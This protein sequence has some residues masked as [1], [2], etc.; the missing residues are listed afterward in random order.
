MRA[1]TAEFVIVAGRP[2][3]CHSA[4]FAI[5]PHLGDNKEVGWG[6]RLAGDG[7]AVD[8]SDVRSRDGDGPQ[9]RRIAR[10]EPALAEIRFDGREADTFSNGG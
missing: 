3:F 7:D 1:S 6:W 5:E 9:P 2:A 10:L 8:F 4:I